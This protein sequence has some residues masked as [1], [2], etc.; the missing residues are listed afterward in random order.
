MTCLYSVPEKR[1]ITN[2]YTPLCT[3]QMNVHCTIFSIQ[4]ILHI[5]AF[6]FMTCCFTTQTR[7][8]DTDCWTIEIK[9]I[10]GVQGK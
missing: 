6:W 4:N 9:Q 8:K 5:Q 7:L 2:S 1:F 3:M 10:K